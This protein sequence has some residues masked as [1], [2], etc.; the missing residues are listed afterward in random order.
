MSVGWH[1]DH[2][3]GGAH[4]EAYQLFCIAIPYL[5]MPISTSTTMH[6]STHLPAMGRFYPYSPCPMGRNDGFHAY[7]KMCGSLWSI[8]EQGKHLC[9]GVHYNRHLLQSLIPHSLWGAWKL[10]QAKGVHA[11]FKCVLWFSTLKKKQLHDPVTEMC[12]N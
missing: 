7:T 1:V 8:E 9:P 2:G 11:I 5:N 6:S 3:L 12:F 4:L 10:A